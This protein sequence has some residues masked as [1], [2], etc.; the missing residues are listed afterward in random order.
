MIIDSHCHAWARWPYQPSVPDPESRGSVEQLIFEMDANGVDA[1][2]VVCAEIDDNPANNEYVAE[3][4]RRYPARLHQVADVD[5]LWKPTYHTAGAAQRL[6]FAARRWSLKGFTHYLRFEDDGSWLPGAEGTVFFEI[7]AEHGLIA[8]LHCHPHQQAAIHAVA[9][10]FPTLPILI[11]HLGHPRIGDEAGLSQILAS[12]E[13]EN[14]VLKVSGFYY[15]LDSR[16]WDYPYAAVQPIIR[17]V[18]EHFG[19]RRM[20]W[21]SDYPV[22]RPFMTYRQTLEAVRQHCD[23][24]PAADQAWVLGGTLARLLGVPSNT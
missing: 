8:S 11:H 2:L 18:Y 17:A 4:V 6:R 23:F 16:Q 19:A 14:I 13:C 21:G 15:A 22:S 20:C 1:A 9:R 24:I 12:A 3:A 5:S 10:R 7:A